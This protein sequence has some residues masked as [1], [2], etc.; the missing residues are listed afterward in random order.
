MT[1]SRKLG[2]HHRLLLGL[3]DFLKHP[4]YSSWLVSFS[5]PGQVRI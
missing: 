1:A 4:S 5:P 3:L 2:H